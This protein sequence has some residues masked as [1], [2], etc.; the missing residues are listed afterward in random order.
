[1]QLPIPQLTE[2][3]DMCPELRASLHDHLQTFSESQRAHIPMT[4]Q[5][6]ILGIPAVTPVLP[7]QPVSY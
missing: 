1:M 2:A 3:L 7:I 4:V 5:D 6:I